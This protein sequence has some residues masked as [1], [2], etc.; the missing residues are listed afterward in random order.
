VTP[1]TTTPPSHSRERHDAAL[2]GLRGIAVLMVFVFHYGGGL[3]SS[4]HA[5]RILGYLTQTG[6]I[7]VVLFFALSGFLITGGLWDSLQDAPTHKLA[8]LRNFYV[9]R[10]L[11]ILPLYFAALLAAV[12]ASIA[13]GSLFSDLRPL[14]IFALFLQDLPVLAQA[15]IHN[16]SPLPLYHLWSLAVEEQFY[17]LWP[18]LLLL[19]RTRRGAIH[20]CLWIFA[21]AAAFRLIVFGLPALAWTHQHHLFD[22]F[23]L[24]QCG[25]L[26]LGAA[27]ALALRPDQQL[28]DTRA[29]QSLHRWA[30]P[31]F[32]TGLT[33][34][35]ISSLLCGSLYLYFPL[36]Y[37]LGL[38]AVSVV[39]AA[40]LLILLRPGIPR[41]IASFAPLAWL[42]RISYGFYVL[43]ILLQPIYDALGERLAHAATGTL[44]QSARFA[45][46]FPITVLAA[47]I[48]YHL[49]ELPFLQAKWRFPLR[50]SLP[51]NLE[52]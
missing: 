5:V 47:W 31:A 37:M 50:P 46:A 45:V 33:L 25:A 20:L 35:L 17:L 27:L 36:Q 19:A 30:T 41:T 7:G 18:A 43:H 26:A 52:P 14:V 49:L 38:P 34:Y 8:V 44:Y 22:S 3:Q 28:S 12:V 11:R 9:R 29:M 24:T 4:H 32:L 42:G 16:V 21:I 1:P 13:F 48:S 2:D 40:L 15:A 39:A 51:Q 6:W 10:A 23:L